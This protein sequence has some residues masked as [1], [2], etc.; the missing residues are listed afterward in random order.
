L[1]V[2]H[3]EGDDIN[4]M[5]ALNKIIINGYELEF[6]QDETILEVA[7][8]NSIDIPTLCYLKGAHSTGQ[9]GICAVE[10]EGTKDLIQACSSLAKN[11]MIVSTE[12]V[13]VIELRRLIL[14][15]MLSLGNHNCAARNT[16]DGDWTGFQ[17]NVQKDDHTDQLCPV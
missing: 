5:E 11:G 7:R 2:K 17:L 13:K 10:V 3:V 12:S 14:K 1:Q 4:H 6:K 15:K 9:C 8:R 16:D